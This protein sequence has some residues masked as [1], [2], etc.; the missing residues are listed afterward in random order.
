ML[1]SIER[2]AHLQDLWSIPG[3]GGGVLLY[4]SHITGA[5]KGCIVLGSF[6]SENSYK[7]RPFW[8]GIRFGFRGTY[9]SVCMNVVIVSAAHESERNRNM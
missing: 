5:H 1:N 6:W 4:T 2:L 3:V 8:S 9:W 7:R